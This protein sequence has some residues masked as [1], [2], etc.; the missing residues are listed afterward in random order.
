M[1]YIAYDPSIDNVDLGDHRMVLSKALKTRKSDIPKNL[2]A[3]EDESD[4]LT[5]RK[6]WIGLDKK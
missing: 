2:L 1:S 6:M 4:T 3:E 5:Q